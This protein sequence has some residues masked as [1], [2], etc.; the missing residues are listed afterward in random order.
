[1]I[2]QQ[3]FVLY[4]VEVH[5]T[6]RTREQWPDYS[7]VID[8]LMEKRQAEILDYSGEAGLGPTF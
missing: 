1:M 4:F 3:K 2:R 7:R 8:N 5:Y 6:P